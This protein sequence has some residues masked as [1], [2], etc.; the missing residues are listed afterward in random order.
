VTDDAHHLTHRELATELRATIERI[1]L[2]V[3]ARSDPVLTE[4]VTA[5]ELVVEITTHAHDHALENRDRIA[6][7]EGLR[8]PAGG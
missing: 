6:V 7:L 2:D 3:E 8:P 5:L 1:K 4:V